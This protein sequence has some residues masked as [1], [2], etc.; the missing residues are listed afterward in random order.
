VGQ[1]QPDDWGDWIRYGLVLIVLEISTFI[2]MPN[3]ERQDLAFH[4]AFG[5][6]IFRDYQ[7]E[8]TKVSIL[9]RKCTSFRCHPIPGI[10]FHGPLALRTLRKSLSMLASD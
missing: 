4:G 7:T 6:V 3:V 8:G 2:S 1:N 10:I 5:C 9:K